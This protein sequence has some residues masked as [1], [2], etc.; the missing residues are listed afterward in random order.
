MLQ[1]R[2]QRRTAARLAREAERV[3]I[4]QAALYRDL[5]REISVVLASPRST[6]PSSTPLSTRMSSPLTTTTPWCT[7]TPMVR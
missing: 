5:N 2:Q 4:Q 1:L 7:A 3:R 6:G